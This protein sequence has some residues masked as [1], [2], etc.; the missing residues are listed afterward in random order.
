MV[1]FFDLCT[2]MGSYTALGGL[3][4][5]LAP[6]TLQTTRATLCLS[7]L[8]LTK[9]A[10]P[11]ALISHLM[12]QYRSFVAKKMAPLTHGNPSKVLP[13]LCM[14]LARLLAARSL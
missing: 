4:P 13:Y 14:A 10:V 11:L 1:I 3:I 2:L 12:V 7:S 5:R 6:Q 8:H 9:R